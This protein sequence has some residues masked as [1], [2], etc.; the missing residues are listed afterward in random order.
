M[1][2][3]Q[4]AYLWNGG[5]DLTLTPYSC[6]KGYAY[7]IQYASV[8][9]WGPGTAG[10]LK[11]SSLSQFIESESA[12]NSHYLGLLCPSLC[13]RVHPWCFH[14][15]STQPRHTTSQWRSGRGQINSI[16]HHNVRILKSVYRAPWHTMNFKREDWS[17][18]KTTPVVSLSR[19]LDVLWLF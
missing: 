3:P 19:G 4:Y 1:S 18:S 8:C 13:H 7:K 2:R 12:H 10:L 15:F 11:D 6:S 9:H 17:L 14:E 16:S 5:G